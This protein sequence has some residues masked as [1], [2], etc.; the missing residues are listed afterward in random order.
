MT[1]QTTTKH[2]LISAGFRKELES[3]GLLWPLVRF[4]Q[5]DTS[6]DLQIRHESINIYFRGGSLIHIEPNKPKGYGFKFDPNYMKKLPSVLKGIKQV[7]AAL[8][9]VVLDEVSLQ[10]WL[11]ALPMLKQAMDHYGPSEERD[12][13][14]QIV[15]T[16]N[17]SS[18]ARSTDWFVCDVEVTL[19]PNVD[20]ANPNKSIDMIALHWQSKGA[21]RKKNQGLDWALVEVKYGLKA[22]SGTS[23][24]D[25][26]LKDYQKAISS[27]KWVNELRNELWQG[28]NLRKD[29]K[30][31]TGVGGKKFDGSL[32]KN[33]L[34]ANPKIMFV[35]A[36]CDPDSR[37]LSK[38]ITELDQSLSQPEKDQLIFMQSCLMGYGLYDD[39]RLT[40]EDMLDQKYL[41]CQNDMK[42]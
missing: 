42:S 24:L 5:Q 16:N 25:A 23:G 37:K 7:V 13:Q 30:L 33:S 35:L 6:L 29:L 41:S 38:W 3:G 12:A 39:A 10:S 20:P 31:I 18:V 2:R 14:Q 22:L 8:P 21:V 32:E 36:N 1:P 11:E 4:V 19:G 27:P 28:F 9:K 26:H 15:W 17:R 40:F 34:S